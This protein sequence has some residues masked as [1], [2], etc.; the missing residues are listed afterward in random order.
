M[1]ADG[2]FQ[3]K[4]IHDIRQLLDMSEHL[5]HIDNEPDREP[6]WKYPVL[7]G[8]TDLEQDVLILKSDDY[9]YKEIKRLLRYEGSIEGL[10]Q[11]CSRARKKAKK[12]MGL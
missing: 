10:Y 1:D 12:N 5:I 6:Y 11:I 2:N 3:D 9:H 8:L 4:H 7:Q